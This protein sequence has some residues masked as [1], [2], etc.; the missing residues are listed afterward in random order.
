META[1]DR[2]CVFIP[3]IL[4]NVYFDKKSFKKK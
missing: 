3:G 1:E 2:K 4:L